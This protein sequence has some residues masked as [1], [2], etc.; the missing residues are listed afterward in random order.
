MTH[1]PEA[2]VLFKRVNHG[3]EAKFLFGS[4]TH[5]P[6]AEV[7]FVTRLMVLKLKSSSGL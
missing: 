7:I 5:G 3:P 1:G 2:V 6:E 4:M